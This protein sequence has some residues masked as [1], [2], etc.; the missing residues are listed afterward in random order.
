MPDVARFHDRTVTLTDGRE[1]DP[2]LVVFATGY[3][4]RFEFLD[5][6]VLGD[7]DG[8]GRPRLWLN[9][10]TAG[11][12]TLAVVGLVQ[13]DSGMFPI[14]HWQSVLFA[15][16]LA[17]RVTRPER[18]AAFGRKVAAGL[19]E[20]YSGKVKDSTRH[21]FESG[22]ST[23]CARS[24]VPCTTWRPSEREE[25]SGAEPRSRE[26]RV[27]TVTTSNYAAER[28]TTE[29]KVF[30]VTGGDWDTVVS[31]TDPINDERIVVNMGP[32]HPSPTACSG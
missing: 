17:L 25:C 18:A 10:F 21:W 5:G 20:R 16:L 11:H 3:L 9:A 27:G 4:P 31:G 12:P 32:Q 23:T 26:R 6:A 2:E 1:I 19:G 13:P 24:S 15:R 7:A 8:S 22:T 28:E 14:A 29:G 30:T